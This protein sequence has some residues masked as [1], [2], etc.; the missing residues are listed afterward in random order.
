MSETVLVV[1]GRS[2]SLFEALLL[3]GLLLAAV[4]LWLAAR[5][6]RARAEQEAASAERARELDERMEAVAR[7]QAALAG[8][9]QAVAESLGARQSDVQRAVSE[10]LDAVTH[11]LG[12][13]LLDSTR[14]TAEGLS[15]LNERLAMIDSARQS[16]GALA[17][18]VGGL[19]S[20]LADKQARG[21]FGQARMEAIVGDGLPVSS[22]AF[23]PT[24]SNGKRPDCGIRLPNTPELLI[25]DAKFPLEGVL[26]WRDA[27]TPE[28]LKATA[29]RLRTD[30]ARHVDDIA[31][32]YRI[33]GETQDI[34][35]MF[36]PSESVFADLH[37]S[38]A[39]VVQR[40]FRLKV[41]LVSPSL[42]LM[43]IQVMQ[44]LVRDARMREEARVIQA[45][46]GHLLEDVRRLRDR[47]VSLERH[48][49]QTVED[50]EKILVSSDKIARRGARIEA[51]ELGDEPA[52][53][54][55][56]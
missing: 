47:A 17:S 49:G 40:A 34:A 43:A 42:L 16:I 37:E 30:I 33:P 39:D 19:R 32:K 28:E 8:R 24:L 7:E 15:K 4:G 54:A 36:V 38:F 53:A 21:A 13:S 45:E 18:E 26:A 3:G 14:Y 23:Q 50:V 44:A 46:V 20:I 1:L 55:A 29:Q 56:E 27:G 48:F 9:L 25:V 12:Q 31:G 41:V 11:R 6:T 22:Y 51:V 5:A 52:R 35:L 2:V 10:R